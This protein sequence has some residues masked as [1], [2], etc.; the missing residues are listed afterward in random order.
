MQ[1]QGQPQFHSTRNAEDTLQNI[2]DFPEGGNIAESSEVSLNQLAE[3]QAEAYQVSDPLFFHMWMYALAD[4]PLIDGI[5]VLAKRYFHETFLHRLDY[6]SFCR[7]VEEVYCSTPPD[8]R[9]LRDLVVN[10]TLDHL[11]TLRNSRA[12]SDYL[13]KQIPDFARDLCIAMI[14]KS[15][16]PPSLW[17]LTRQPS[18][19]F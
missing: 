5:K 7:A 15:V 8:E 2:A 18:F 10:V 14:N 4:R 11:T 17:F 1:H 6:G 19:K 3:S 12:L 16:P 13:L 9:G